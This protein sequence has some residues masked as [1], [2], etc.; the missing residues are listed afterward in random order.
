MYQIEEITNS[1]LQGHVLDELRKMPSNSVNCM[2][3]SPP[4]YGLRSYGTEH[5]I[6]GGDNL[7]PDGVSNWDNGTGQSTYRN[8]NFRP[9]PKG[10]NK[11]TV[12]SIN[13][14]SSREQHFAC[15][16][17]KLIE[18]PIL[19]CCP[20]GGIVLD[21]FFGSGT[22]GLVAQTLNRN[23]IGIELNPE[24]VKIAEKKIG[25]IN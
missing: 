12:W 17:K 25:L 13:T 5:Q 4:Y 21:I 8:R 2:I 10:R 16:P 18:T 9:N 24:Y 15:Y 3:T 22:T 1:I 7:I 14:E 11:R 19:S 6:W 20:E 23:W